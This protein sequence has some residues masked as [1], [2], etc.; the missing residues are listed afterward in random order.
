[1]PEPP[2]NLLRTYRPFQDGG[3]E[4]TDFLDISDELDSREA[5]TLARPGPPSAPMVT[6]DNVV[7]TTHFRG[8]GSLRVELVAVA[9]HP[10]ARR[11][12]ITSNWHARPPCQLS[13]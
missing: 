6:G 11:A 10:A 5:T 3:Y 13:E 2:I 7:V 1:M 12:V 4:A 9:L 8:V